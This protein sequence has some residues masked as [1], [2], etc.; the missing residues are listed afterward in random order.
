MG[1]EERVR[2]TGCGASQA[3]LGHSQRN[4]RLAAKP[5]PERAATTASGVSTLSRGNQEF[6]K[7]RSGREQALAATSHRSLPHRRHP[8][9][10]GDVDDAQ[11]RDRAAHQQWR[12]QVQAAEGFAFEHAVHEG[13]LA[14][15]RHPQMP[16]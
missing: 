2:R 13:D 3:E 14:E 10:P 9:M 16:G 4:Q 11:H 6:V 15:R 1:V 12:G 5:P 8:Q 7:K